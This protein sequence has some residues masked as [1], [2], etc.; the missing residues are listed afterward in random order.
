MVLFILKA[1]NILLVLS[2]Y[3]D[4]SRRGSGP[5]ATPL[6]RFTHGEKRSTSV[7]QIGV[8]RCPIYAMMVEN[9]PSWM[10][11][12]I[13]AICRKFLC[14]WAAM[15]LSE[16]N[17]WWL[18]R[19]ADSLPSSEH[20]LTPSSATDEQPYSGSIDGF[21]VIALETSLHVYIS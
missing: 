2:A 14:G 7:D 10:R 16:E 3:K 20:P 17:V 8:I 15:L 13:D 5:K 18:G 4:P 9:L 1:N 6:S 21:M 11:K 19:L 12:E